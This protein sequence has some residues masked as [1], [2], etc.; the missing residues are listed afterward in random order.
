MRKYYN[1]NIIISI[2]SL[3]PNADS[4][5]L[6]SAMGMDCVR[7]LLF[8]VTNFDP[9]SNMGVPIFTEQPCVMPNGLQ[10]RYAKKVII[11]TNNN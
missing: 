9:T 11:K 5:A 7:P 6:A 4:L 10:H 3:Q 8:A 1:Y 2:H